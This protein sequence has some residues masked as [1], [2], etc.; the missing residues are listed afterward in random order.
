MAAEPIP[1]QC[2]FI[3]DLDFGQFS[4]L[5]ENKNCTGRE[6]FQHVSTCSTPCC[7]RAYTIYVETARQSFLK[8]EARLPARKRLAHEFDIRQ[9][10][11]ALRAGSTVRS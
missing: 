5:V 6:T 10:L 8:T 1:K 11:A 9:T 7:M 2:A 3:G 4:R